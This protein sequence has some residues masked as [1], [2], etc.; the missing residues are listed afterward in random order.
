MP[1]TMKKI[2]YLN[3]LLKHISDLAILNKNIIK[4]NSVHNDFKGIKK[5]FQN[6]NYKISK[7]DSSTLL[8]ILN[9]DFKIP[10]S[11]LKNMHYMRIDKN[12]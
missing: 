9:S 3:Q 6:N 11:E 1:S 8:Y 7:S 5:A 12:E 4:I 10:H 2:I